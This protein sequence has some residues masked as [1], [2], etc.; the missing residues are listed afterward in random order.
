[1]SIAVVYRAGCIA[2]SRKRAINKVIARGA[3]VDA[4]SVRVAGR[5]GTDVI[6]RG[7][8]VDAVVIRVACRRG[9]GVIV[10]RVVVD[11][12]VVAQEVQARYVSIGFACHVQPLTVAGTKRAVHLP[13]VSLP[14]LRFGG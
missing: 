6:E 11:A 4:V 1:M 7:G 12:V 9:A 8:V 14:S 2:S 13:E 5:R 3:V 10:A